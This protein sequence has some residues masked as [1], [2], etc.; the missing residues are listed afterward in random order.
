MKTKK[1]E[2][3]LGRPPDPDGDYT[4]AL[5]ICT[6][7]ALHTEKIVQVRSSFYFRKFLYGFA[8]K[9]NKRFVNQTIIQTSVKVFRIK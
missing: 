3:K 2:I 1:I 4:K 8:K 7:M 5:N 9:A 6:Y